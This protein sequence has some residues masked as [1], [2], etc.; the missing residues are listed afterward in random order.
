MVKIDG[1]RMIAWNGD[2][3]DD[4]GIIWCMVKEN[5]PGYIPMTG[6]DDLQAPWYLAHFEHHRDPYDGG[7]DY[8]SARAAAEKTAMRYNK[9]NG[10]TEEDVEVIFTSSMRL[11]K[12]E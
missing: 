12:P 10:Y 1:L 3:T 2:L 7:L 9:Q 4:Y 11:G 6:R 5:T 8:A